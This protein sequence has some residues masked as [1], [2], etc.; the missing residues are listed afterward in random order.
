MIYKSVA[1]V[2]MGGQSFLV[3][4][5]SSKAPRGMLGNT[6]EPLM[7]E[8]IETEMEIAK[9]QKKARRQVLDI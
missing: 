6:M 2:D 5:L 4:S 3:F 1:G 9:Q 7:R 8:S